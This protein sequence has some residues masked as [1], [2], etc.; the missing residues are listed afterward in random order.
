[1]G[2]DGM[3]WD[4]VPKIDGEIAAKNCARFED[5]FQDFSQDWG[6]IGSVQGFFK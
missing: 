6:F 3:D 5:F 4:G 2:W 1:M